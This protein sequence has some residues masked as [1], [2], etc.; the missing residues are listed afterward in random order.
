MRIRALAV[1]YEMPCSMIQ[2]SSEVEE[3]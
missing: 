1:G 3:K 2:D